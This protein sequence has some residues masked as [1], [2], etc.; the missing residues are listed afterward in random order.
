MKTRKHIF[1]FEA[2]TNTNLEGGIFMSSKL[3]AKNSSKNTTSNV[4]KDSSKNY[5]TGVAKNSASDCNCNTSNYVSGD[6][7]PSS[8]NHRF[9][10]E[11]SDAWL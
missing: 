10:K 7:A 6:F 11:D 1:I 2:H 9:T 4:E 3:K 5:T 8:S